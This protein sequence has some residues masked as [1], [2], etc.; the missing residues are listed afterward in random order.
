M[1]KKTASSTKELNEMAETAAKFVNQTDRHIFLTGKAGTGKTTF[2]KRIKSEAKKE[3]VIVAPT[4]IAAINAGGTTIH[5]FFQL[6]FGA[7]VPRD[8][9]NH[10]FAPDAKIHTPSTL[11]KDQRIH[12]KKRKL[13]QALELLI[14]DEVS[15]LRAD[16]LDAIDVVLRKVRRKM[17]LPFG[18]VQLLFIGDLLQLPPVI[19]PQEWNILGQFYKSGFFF[20]AQCLEEDPPVYIELEKIYRQKDADF[21]RILNHLRNDQLTQEDLEVLNKSYQPDFETEG[22]EYIYLTTHNQKADK[23][24]KSRLDKLDTKAFTFKA[25]IEGDF[26]AF[27]YPIELELTLKEGAQVMFIKNDPSGEQRFFNGKIG[28]VCFLSEKEI[29]VKFD[30]GS[31]VEV[32]R[33]LWENIRYVYNEEKGEV[34]EEVIGTFE[35]YPLKLAWAITVHKSQGLTFEKAILDLGHTFAPGQAYVA[36]SRLTGLEGL[37]LDQPINPKMVQVDERVQN[38]VAKQPPKT[39]LPQLFEKAHERFHQKALLSAFEFQKL[40][41][42]LKLHLQSYQKLSGKS[43]KLSYYVWATEMHERV[44]AQEKIANKFIHQL[45][46]L[47]AEEQPA[48]TIAERLY[49]AEKHFS[50]A[51]SVMIDE[52]KA[53][54]VKLSG[55]DK[56]KKFRLELRELEMKLLE[57]RKEI[58]KTIEKDGVEEE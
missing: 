49:A 21:I 51:L 50:Q 41:E 28:K 18:G 33:Y 42:H 1:K 54:V 11:L 14:I 16:I 37:V 57:K 2:L 31:V 47:F 29:M 39:Q 7:F 45:Q 17:Y 48:T 20:N 19:R 8:Y 27:N 43:I 12:Q 34:Q 26:K 22:K 3:S 10:L 58:Q 36:L 9:S 6:P 38:F 4:G 52:V 56:A 15:M 13:M 30:N 44:V 55:K 32:S 25:H 24:N 35:H 40:S 23:I 46:R 53:L 5:S